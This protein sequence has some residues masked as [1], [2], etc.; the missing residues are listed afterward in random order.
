MATNTR[1]IEI[2]YVLAMKAEANFNTM[3][4]SLADG[5][6]ALLSQAIEMEEFKKLFNKMRNNVVNSDDFLTEEEIN[7]EIN[8]A[9]MDRK[10][11]SQRV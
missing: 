2:D 1:N 6:N 3:G 10:T 5:I 4:I 11:R 7:A 8:A 9:R